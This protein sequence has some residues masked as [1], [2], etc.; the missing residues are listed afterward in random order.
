MGPR[1][2]GRRPR[3]S[4][5]R[6]PSPR[7]ESDRDPMCLTLSR[8][9]RHGDSRLRELASDSRETHTHAA[10]AR[11]PGRAQREGEN[12]CFHTRKLLLWFIPPTDCYWTSPSLKLLLVYTLGCARLGHDAATLRRAG[13]R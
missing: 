4:R 8:C 1:P 6:A 11:G 7:R 3:P 5:A 10:G 9:D 13:T 12:A 2:P